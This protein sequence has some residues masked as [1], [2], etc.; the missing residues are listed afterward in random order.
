MDPG[1]QPITLK[2][3]TQVEE[4]LIARVNPVLQVTQNFGGQYKYHGHTISFTQDVKNIANILPHRIHDLD[5]V[6]V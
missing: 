2:R 6:I 1:E 4:M 3:L 5:I